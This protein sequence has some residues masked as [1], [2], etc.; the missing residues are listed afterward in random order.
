MEQCFGDSERY[1]VVHSVGYVAKLI[2]VIEQDRF[3]R[4]NEDPLS[5]NYEF[6]DI[7]RR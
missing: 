6:T 7:S 1:L 5:T 4:F 2:C 3:K